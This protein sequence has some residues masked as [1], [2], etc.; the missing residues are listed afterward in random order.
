MPGFGTE[1]RQVDCGHRV[2][3]GDAQ[4]LT[5]GEGREALAGAQHRQ[6]AQASQSI[7][8]PWWWTGMM[9][10]RYGQRKRDGLKRDARRVVG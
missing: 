9:P 2:G 5:G 4:H 8:A 10:A 1:M 3:C 6:G 7:A